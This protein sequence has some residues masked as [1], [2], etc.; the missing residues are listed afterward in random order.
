MDLNKGSR[1]WEAYGKCWA[2]MKEH[3][4]VT[5]NDDVQDYLSKA[6][7]LEQE[8]HE[9]RNFIGSMLY[10]FGKMIENEWKERKQ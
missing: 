1:L 10:H 9:Y 8:Y 5:C 3:S 7:D 6:R 4:T 2:L